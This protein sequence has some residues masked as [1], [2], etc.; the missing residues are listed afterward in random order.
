M[1]RKLQVLFAG[2]SI[3][4]IGLLAF[5]TVA[6]QSPTEHD[7][8][9]TPQ[10][11]LA[12]PPMSDPPTQIELGHVEY[13]MSCMV[14]HGDRGQGLT[15]E[16]RSV[17]DP[18]DM[19]CWQSK[20]HAPNHPPEGFEI[21]RQSP[22]V[23]GPGALTGYETATDLFEYLRTNMPWAFP[24]LFEDDVYWNLTAY[25]AQANDID[26]PQETLSLDNGDD[27][28]MIP[29]LVQTHQTSIHTEQMAAGVVVGLLLV[30]T[31][32]FGL[33]RSL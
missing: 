32:L 16:W 15:E 18:E 17:L 1:N 21:P 30:A 5:S 14:C 13:W 25:L 26:F 28:L 11:R 8:G 19:N 9:M 22:L 24:G 2:I 33:I 23:I 6:A 27:V 31:I 10:E 20:C 4:I 3:V 29:Q 7:A 12:R